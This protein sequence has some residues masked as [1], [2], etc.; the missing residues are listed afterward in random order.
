MCASRP[1]LA[2]A[3]R[4]KSGAARFL[5]LAVLALLILPVA[6]VADD[7][8]GPADAI[9]PGVYRLDGFDPSLPLD[10]LEPLRRIVGAAR[11]V[12]LGES[13]HTSGGFYQ[14][15]HRVFRFLVEE[16]GFR[17]FGFETPWLNAEP[18]VAYVQTCE[19]N[20][21]TLL[22]GLS[23]PWRSAEVGDLLQWM[24]EWNRS[25]PNPSDRLHFYGFD[26]QRQAQGNGGTLIAYLEKI[27][28]GADHPWIQGIQTCDGVVETF[29]PAQPFPAELYEQ[30]QEALTEVAG[31]F[32]VNEKALTQRTSREE[33]AWARIHLVGQQAWQEMLFFLP[34]DFLRSYNARERGMAY[35]AQAIRNLRFPNARVAL[36]GH[37]G[38]IMY[39]AVPYVGTPGMG[40][41][42]SEALG[43]RYV[44][45]ALTASEVYADW[46]PAG[47]CGLVDLSVPSAVAVEDV[48]RGFGEGALL[49][50][51][52]PR[53][54][55]PS[56]LEPGAVYGLADGAF[57]PAE[58]FD[59]LLY[60]KASP[61]MHPTAWAPCQ[62]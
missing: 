62:P 3:R 21:A 23:R 56:L 43:S 15:K 5:V 53:G 48:L 2:R 13:F 49:V 36:W 17:V 61:A 54:S 41:Y 6:A 24:C 10:D 37:N 1:S 51:L 8:N 27:G 46:V 32:D 47:R 33:L 59:A 39:D 18:L 4:P 30:C 45:V 20:L 31:F 12:G 35:V 11:V 60:L 50:D 34:T 28:F 14:L 22:D 52:D 9:A 29:W 26:N 42:L 38:H 16:M 55:H 19:G 44:A 58:Q 57:V 25:H 7:G 40:N